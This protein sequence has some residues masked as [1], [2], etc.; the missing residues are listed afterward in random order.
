MGLETDLG[1][2]SN[3]YGLAMMLL[4]IAYVVGQLPSNF[5][6]A[7]GRPSIYLPAAMTL[8]GSV[9]TATTFVRT[10]SELYAVRSLLG[11]LEAPFAVGCL[12]LISSFYTR[13][14]LCLRSAILL[15][16]PSTANALAGIISFGIADSIDGALGLTGWRWLFII[17]GASTVAMAC[18]AFYSLPDFPENTRW[19]DERERA[20][21]QLRMIADGRG[22][23]RKSSRREGLMLA[24]SS[25][26]VWTFAGMFF[27]L[28]IGTSLHNFFPSVVQTLGFPRDTT[29]WMTGPPYLL[30]VVVSIANALVADRHRNASFHI[31]GP[32]VFAMLGFLVFLFE[33]SP[34]GKGVWVRYAS[35]FLMLAGAHAAAPVVLA[36]AQKTL[37]E[38]KE[39]RA[40]AIAIINTSGT[41]AQI[42]TSELYPDRW[43]PRYIQ[44]MSLNTACGLGAILL[45]IFMRTML[46]RQ[47]KKI[48]EQESPAVGTDMQRVSGRDKEKQAT[49]RSYRYVT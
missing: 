24:V 30:A 3:E 32:T 20:V 37:Q 39:M 34:H 2:K 15:S 8:W 44:S 11:L 7:K 16:A 31:I 38:P 49:G 36:W 18:F 22:P 14:E 9:C 12:L 33:Q 5:Y 1:M 21:T 28:V 48:V 26:R 13:S 29:L 40:C 23:G 25:W 4:F 45:A 10:P 19:L 42:A 43:A 35:T 47:N 46:R 6:L 17:G 41:L 27:L